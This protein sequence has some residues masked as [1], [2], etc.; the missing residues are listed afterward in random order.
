MVIAAPHDEV[1]QGANQLLTTTLL[2]TLLGLALL[3][4]LIWW[5]AHRMTDSLRQLA[6]TASEIRAFRFSGEHSASLVREVDALSQAMQQM[7]T[8][9]QRFLDISTRLAGERNYH[10]LLEEI[11]AEASLAANAGA[12]V[13]Y[14][15]DDS[16]R[17]H[18]MAWRG[19]PGK[20]AL[21]PEA[22]LRE[23]SALFGSA[24]A[25]PTPTQAT[26]A[27]AHLPPGLAWLG[28]CFPGQSAQILLI[29]LRN[30]SGDPLGLLLLA[31]GEEA[32]PYTPDLVAFIDALSGTMAVTI[33]KQSLLEG[34]KALLDG[35]IR[36]IGGAI[37]ARSPYTGAHCQ[38]VPEL[39]AM[40]AEA[41]ATHPASPFRDEP[42]DEGSRE[43]LH[44]A[45]WL[46]DCG[47]LF[48][49]DYVADKSVKLEAVYNRIHEIRTRFEVLKRDAQLD[50][51]RGLAEGKDGALLQ[52]ELEQA[53]Q[54]IDDDFSF[55]AHCNLGD[56]ALDEAAIARLVGIGERTWLR[57][58]DDRLGIS[59]LELRRKAGL[60]PRALPSPE[61]LLADRL[62]HLIGF[63]VTADKTTAT[64]SRKRM[65]QPRHRLNLGELYCLSVKSGTLTREERY[66]INAH[67]LGTMDMLSTLPFP[68]ELSQV[69]ETAAGHHEHLDGSGYPNGKQAKDLS[70]GTRII[71]IA[72]VF[73]ALT[74]S[75]RPY[76][77]G[78]SVDQ[79]LAIMASMAHKGHLD[80]Q[81]FEL[82]MAAGIPA[83]YAAAHPRVLGEG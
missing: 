72:D 81:L 33:E 30:R 50:Y 43:A 40:L 2:S 64:G 75:D 57:T 11:V 42:Y 32:G 77:S 1:L 82:F 39:V 55:V 14:L 24:L 79:A 21:L 28:S 35:M 17:L 60:P 65:P 7:R 25:R 61:H 27:P 47:K 13:V 5:I 46:H 8:T 37:D 38:R 78:K 15:L 83:R 6:N 9:I 22:I 51:W 58:L 74:A 63:H 10:Q 4:P 54:A 41:A 52:A 56:Q 19:M 16:R 20:A 18:P 45:A 68:R 80:P 29:P 59:E 71:A 69:P 53:L 49:P 36:M 67:I 70:T 26:L 3:L 12:G 62:E 31:R 34:R 73:E 44:L 23:A 66:L 76:K 48:V